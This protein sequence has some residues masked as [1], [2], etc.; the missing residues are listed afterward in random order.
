MKRVEKCKEVRLHSSGLIL[1]FF[2]LNSGPEANHNAEY[3]LENENTYQSDG[4][5]IKLHGSGDFSIGTS[6]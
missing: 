6:S 3:N 4:I 2:D 1:L 5:R